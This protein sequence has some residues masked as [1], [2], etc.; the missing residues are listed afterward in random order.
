MFLHKEVEAERRGS[1]SSLEASWQNL[2]EICSYASTIVFFRPEQFRWPVLMSCMAVF[3]AGILYTFFIR[4][5]RGHLLHLPACIALQDRKTRSSE[6]VSERL[7]FD[8]ET[9]DSVP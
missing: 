7:L 8:Q 2:F 5:Q 4:S 6:P 3:F 1:F 9:S